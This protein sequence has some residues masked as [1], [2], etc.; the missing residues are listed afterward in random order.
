[1]YFHT[2]HLEKIR[3]HVLPRKIDKGIVVLGDMLKFGDKFA[4][5]VFGSKFLKKLRENGL[6]EHD[7]INAFTCKIGFSY[8]T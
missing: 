4:R 2:L 8:Y 7:L 1:M 3:I 5:K 6:N